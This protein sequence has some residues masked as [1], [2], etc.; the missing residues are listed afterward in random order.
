M[1][2]DTYSDLQTEI[3]NWL[4]RSDL[5][6][7]IPEFIELAESRFDREITHHRLIKR[8]T[9]DMDTEYTDL[10]DD[11]IEAI[12]VRL[13][14]TPSQ[15]LQPITPQQAVRYRESYTSAG[16]PAFYSIIEDTIWALPRP[17]SSYTVEMVYRA[18]LPKLSD[19]NTTNWLLTN[20]PDLY[21]A[22]ALVEGFGY[23]M[24]EEREA[25]WEQ[26]LV[27]GLQSL[28]KESGRAAVGGTPVARAKP[29]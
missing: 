10:P 7:Q 13:T 26:R 27:R 16:R 9:A 4:N 20:Y 14:T 8:S 25:K 19:S 18:R 11:W 3:G 24:D 1:A 29:F 17:D 6:A 23:V 5:T 12:S 28:R 15:T 22:G 2:I 21:L